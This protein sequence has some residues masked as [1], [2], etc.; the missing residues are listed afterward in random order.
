MSRTSTASS[1]SPPRPAAT[2]LGRWP[3]GW[4]RRRGG[5]PSHP[6]GR[7]RGVAEEITTELAPGSVELRLRGRDPEFVVTPPPADPSADDLAEDPTTGLQPSQRATRAR[8]RG[9]TSACPTTS[10][11]GSSR[12]PRAKGCRSTPGSCERL[13]PP[14]NEPACPVNAERRALP[15]RQRYTAGHASQPRKGTAD[16]YLRYSRTDLRHRRV[17]RR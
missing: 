4:S 12:Q 7:A 8:C 13:P 11:P 17:R 9:S 14:W 1:R 6:A 15:G 3:S 2:R 5:D 16:A 10:R